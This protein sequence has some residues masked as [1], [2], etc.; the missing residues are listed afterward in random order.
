VELVVDL[1]QAVL[2]VLADEEAHGDDG[3]AG[4]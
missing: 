4:E 1:D 2:A 3:S